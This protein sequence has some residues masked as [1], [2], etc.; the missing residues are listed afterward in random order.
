M[1]TINKYLEIKLL[2]NAFAGLLSLFI[3]TK[4]NVFKII[5]SLRIKTRFLKQ[6]FFYHE[7]NILASF[8]YNI[9]S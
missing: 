9:C 2:L 1:E 4:S 3:I 6:I 5:L 8:S 7:T